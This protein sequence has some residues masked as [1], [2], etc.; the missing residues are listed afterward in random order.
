VE[1]VMITGGA[2]FIGH[3]LVERYLQE[4]FKVTVIDDLSNYNKNFTLINKDSGTLS[5]HNFSFYRKDIADRKEVL[6][7]F[8]HENV[9]SCI[10]LAAKISVAESVKNPWNTIDVNI[11]G[12]LNVLEACSINNVNSFVFGSSAAVYGEPGQLPIKESHLLDPLSPYGASKVAGEALVST[13]RNLKKIKNPSS[14]RFFNVF[15]KGQT[16]QY[17][18]VITKFTE[19]LSQRLPPIIYGDG[20]QTRD[21]ISVNDVVS[22]IMLAAKLNDED[23]NA[24][25][26]VYN[27]A[28]GR[29]IRIKDLARL[30]IKMFK[31][32]ID[33]IFV[34]TKKGD[35]VNSY[36][37]ITKTKEQLRFVATEK[38]NSISLSIPK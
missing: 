17:A 10:H 8:K 36:A 35:I 15:G 22:A 34:E 38:I 14:L 20:N 7:I 5:N 4:G 21:F 9:H 29:P 11:R 19:R 31:L 2:G 33:P 37:D 23:N 6:D 26:M 13:Y 30:M 12:T 25:N 3:C 27:I 32:D 16:P 24:N 1:K 18:G 28:T